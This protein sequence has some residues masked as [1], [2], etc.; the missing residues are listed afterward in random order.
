MAGV[1]CWQIGVGNADGPGIRSSRMLFRVTRSDVRTCSLAAPVHS[2]CQMQAGCREQQV[3]RQN[4]E[5]VADIQG[6][7]E[8]G[9]AGSKVEVWQ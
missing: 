4:P 7:E 2:V 1:N 3:V 8:G 5:P 6:S 9:E